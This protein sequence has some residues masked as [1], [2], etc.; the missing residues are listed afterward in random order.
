MTKRE[1][2]QV[3]EMLRCAADERP[4][5]GLNGMFDACGRYSDKTI[6]SAWAALLSVARC[7]ARD[8]VA[9][10]LPID[11]GYRVQLLEAASRVEERS[12]P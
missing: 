6:N 7:E 1:R 11:E 9:T 10:V 2:E 12:W 5:F 3:V 4:D 8:F